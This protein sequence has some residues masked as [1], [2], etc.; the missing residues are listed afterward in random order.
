MQQAGAKAVYLHGCPCNK[1]VW[2]PDDD[3]DECEFCGG[4]R[5][6]DENKP[7][8]FVVHF[9]LKE[10]LRSLLKL[11]QYVKAVRWELERNARHNRNYVTDVYDTKWWQDNMGSVKVVIFNGRRRKLLSRMGFLLC[12]DG[13]PAFHEKHKGAP[14]LCPAELINL[15]QGPHERYDPDNM[16]SWMLIPNEYSAETQEKFFKYVIE[17]EMNPLMTEGVEGPDGPVTIK[18]LGASLDLKGKSLLLL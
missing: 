12:I 9:P 18:V 4:S 8:E 3:S 15:S 16:M 5:Y 11:P 2:G 17:T 1:K 6:D 10:R 7:R 13:V 14:T